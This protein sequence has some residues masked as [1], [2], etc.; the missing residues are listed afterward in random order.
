MI[1]P[2]EQRYLFW[3][4][5]THW[6]DVGHVVEM[7]PWLGGSSYCLLEGMQAAGAASTSPHKL[8]VFDNFVW[9]EFM[10]GRGGPELD[11]GA[12]FESHFRRTLAPH[13]ARLAVHNAWLPDDEAHDDPEL[14][15]IR[16]PIPP[17]AELV[18]W[19]ADDPVEILFVD[20]AKS[21][22]GMTA[23]LTTFVDA[24]IPDRSL[25]VFQDYKYWGEYWVATL[26]ELLS[27]TLT[28]Q[29]QTREN[30][31]T[32]RVGEGLDRARIESLPRFEDC[33][34][35][36]LCRL[37]EQAGRRIGGHGSA[38]DRLIVELTKIRMLIHKNDRS[39]AIE[40]FR[41]IES[42]WPLLGNGFNLEAARSW[43]QR[44]SGTTLAPAMRSKTRAATDRILRPLRR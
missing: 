39:G 35:D 14:E 29:H 15:A 7:G 11:D 13:A 37:L 1:S 9:R 17:D 23:L 3:L 6:K 38:T 18:T 42:R 34:A 2:E 25:L 16:E 8:H 32:F 5:R 44:T 41:D 27:D 36:E 31:V 26:V 12:S 40:A 43:L 28:F 22:R 10:G 33:E 20:G 21:W 24:L 30:T 19:C 4:T